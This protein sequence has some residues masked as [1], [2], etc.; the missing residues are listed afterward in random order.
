[1]E[2]L[3]ESIKQ[4]EGF[5]GEVYKDTLGFDTIGYGTKLPLSKEESEMI[6]KSRLIQKVKELERREPL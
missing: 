5:R 1:M 4:N 2:K 6:P 3:I